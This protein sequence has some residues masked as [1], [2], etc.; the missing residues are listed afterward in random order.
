[1]GGTCPVCGLFLHVHGCSAVVCMNPQTRAAILRDQAERF[2]DELVGPEAAPDSAPIIAS[3]PELGERRVVCPDCG[4]ELTWPLGQEKP[5]PC[6]RCNE[7][8]DAS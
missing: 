7:D 3:R 6:G 1:M 8:G 5:W 4:N 2:V